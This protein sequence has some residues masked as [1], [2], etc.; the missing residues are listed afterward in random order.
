MYHNLDK[1]KKYCPTNAEYNRLYYDSDLFN[2]I[3]GYLPEYTEK[4]APDVQ[5]RML[6]EK[7]QKG[8]GRKRRSSKN[9]LSRHKYRFY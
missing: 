1:C 9:K 5:K 2:K 6:T 8:S 4:Y 3:T 7:I